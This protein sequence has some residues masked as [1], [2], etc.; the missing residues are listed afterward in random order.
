M[1][2]EGWSVT[3]ASATAVAGA[4]WTVLVRG[5]RHTRRIMYAVEQIERHSIELVPNHGSSLRDQVDRIAVEQNRHTA[6][7]ADHSAVLAEVQRTVAHVAVL[8]AD[9]A[10]RGTT[11]ASATPRSP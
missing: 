8:V 10:A 1:N 3:A 7:L 4:A 9:T 6:V 11:P 2:V 5:G